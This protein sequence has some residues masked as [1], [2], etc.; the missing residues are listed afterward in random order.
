MN[1][2][3]TVY[4]QTAKSSKLH[5]PSK[6]F[7]RVEASHR[8]EESRFYLNNSS[9]LSPRPPFSNDEQKRKI[10]SVWY[11]KFSFNKQVSGSGVLQNTTTAYKYASR[12][13]SLTEE[14]IVNYPHYLIRDEALMVS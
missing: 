14:E 10:F 8:F 7:R 11:Q 4:N 6:H 1:D 5:K 9:V 12:D 3:Y 2:N 13:L